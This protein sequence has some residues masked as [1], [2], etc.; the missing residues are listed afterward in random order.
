MDVW[1]GGLM[2]ILVDGRMEGWMDGWVKGWIGELTYN[3]VDL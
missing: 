3:F 2:D 1:I